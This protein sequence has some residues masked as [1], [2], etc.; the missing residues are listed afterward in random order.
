MEERGVDLLLAC[1]RANVGYLTG[2]TYYV[3]QGLPYVLEDG[4][5]WSI[6]FVGVPR[7]DEIAPFLTPVSSEHG[8]I[9]YADP[10]IEDRRFWGPKWTYSGEASPTSAGA[11]GDVAECVAGAIRER[12]LTEGTIALEIEAIPAARYV[13][14][15]ELLPRARFVD[16]ADILRDLRIIKS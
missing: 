16:A 4:R 7:S 13:R 5:Q 1:S 12:G 6:T 9:A 3:A 11:P 8:S 2:Y 15:R 14:L 10:W